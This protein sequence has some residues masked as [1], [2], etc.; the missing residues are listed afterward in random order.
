[1]LK[2]ILS[3]TILTVIFT[4]PSF[5]EENADTFK[6]ALETAKAAQKAAA[7]VGGEWR[8]IGKFLKK[9]EEAAASGNFNKAVKLAKKATFQAETGK[10]QMENQKNLDFPSYFTK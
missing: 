4:V 1:M 9:A 2:K 5:A 3:I 8:D 6:A 7:D 10:A